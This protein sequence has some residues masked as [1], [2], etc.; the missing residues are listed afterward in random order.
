MHKVTSLR[1]LPASGLFPYQ[2][3]VEK[4]M[5]W[6][7]ARCPT[8]HHKIATPTL[9]WDMKPKARTITC[10]RIS[11]K[12]IYINPF[13]ANKDS[14][15]VLVETMKHDFAHHVDI[16]LNG[17]TGKKHGR[18]FN[19]I[20]KSLGIKGGPKTSAFTGDRKHRKV[21]AECSPACCAVGAI[22]FTKARRIEDGKVY[23]CTQCKTPI[24]IAAMIVSGSSASGSSE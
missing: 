21:R 10:Y 3:R 5:E 6:V 15:A 22:S 8:V 7:R 20:C 13:Y 23:R 1:E 4:L 12:R 2:E 24:R 9:A 17:W 18:S 11:E 14:D 19:E 16:S